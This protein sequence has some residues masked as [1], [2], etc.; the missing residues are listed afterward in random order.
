MNEMP[1]LNIIASRAGKIFIYSEIGAECI[2]E[3]PR[4]KRVVWKAELLNRK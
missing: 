1:A 2:R 4:Q 3:V